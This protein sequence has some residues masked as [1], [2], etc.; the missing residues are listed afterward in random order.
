MTGIEVV[1]LSVIGT[2]TAVIVLR[3]LERQRDSRSMY[4][5]ITHQV[6]TEIT[7][8]YTSHAWSISARALILSPSDGSRHHYSIM[9]SIFT[10]IANI[11]VRH[12]PERGRK[13]NN[14]RARFKLKPKEYPRRE[15]LD[16]TIYVCGDPGYQHP[17][18][19]LKAVA[20]ALPPEVD[21]ILVSPQ[22][23]PARPLRPAR[24]AI[25]SPIVSESAAEHPVHDHTHSA[26]H[27]ANRDQITIAGSSTAV[28]DLFDGVRLGYQVHHG[29]GATSYAGNQ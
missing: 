11:H 25:L 2:T 13:R 14:L 22:V 28:A 4:V 5:P 6:M 1:V 3:Q 20:P 9:R 24:P 29:P 8:H 23:Q 12:P 19:A 18:H 27:P 10:A 17:S 16:H 7:L 15:G 26:T 21:A